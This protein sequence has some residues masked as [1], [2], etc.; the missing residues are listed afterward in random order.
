MQ[1]TDV[2][3]ISIYLKLKKIVKKNICD[4]KKILSKYQ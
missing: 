3:Q 4:A 2:M 1:I